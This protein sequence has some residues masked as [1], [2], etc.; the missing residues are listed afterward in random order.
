MCQCKA[1]GSAYYTDHRMVCVDLEQTEA[2]RGCGYWKLNTNLLKDAVFV[3]MINEVIDRT[4]TRYQDKCNPQLLW[5]VCKSQIR[6]VS[7][8]YSK[9]KQKDRKSDLENIERKLINMQKTMSNQCSEVDIKQYETLRMEFEIKSEAD[10]RGAQ[11]RA[12][13]RA[14]P[15]KI[16][17]PHLDGK[18]FFPW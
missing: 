6:D 9:Q 18:R 3:N 12:K 16:P 2:V 11:I 10:A 13:V 17:P 4:L 7:I 5:D 1:Y 15:G 8:E 14:V